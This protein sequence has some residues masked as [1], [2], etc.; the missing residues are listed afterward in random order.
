MNDNMTLWNSVFQTDPTHTKKFNRAGGFSGTA[1]KP[2]YLARRLTEEFG[3]C[4]KG[5]GFRELRA[6]YKAGV[7][8]SYVELWYKVA[9]QSYSVF[10]WGQTTMEGKNKHGEFVDE[11]APK[12]AITDGWTKAASL[13]GFGGDVHMGQFDDSKYIE[14]R[15]AAETARSRN[16]RFAKVKQA[17]AE[18]FDPAGT[19]GEYLQDI[20]EFRAAD[21]QFYEDLVATGKQR[22]AELEQIEMM[23][24]GMPEEFNNIK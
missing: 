24:A 2:Y 19:W 1:I 4:G 18:S 6:D 14:E 10:Q 22:K 17:I 8:C 23:K 7:W 15:K 13:L 5:W 9:G 3:P 21:A 20:E 12:K 16:E 11:E